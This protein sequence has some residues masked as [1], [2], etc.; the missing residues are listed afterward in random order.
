[1]AESPYMIK[2]RE[3]MLGLRSPDPKKE[4]KPIAKVSEKKKAQ[5][6]A[7]KAAGVK[8]SPRKP[9]P[10]GGKPRGRSEKMRGVVSALRPLYDAFMKDKEECEIKS[11]VCTGRAEYIHHVEGRG[12]KVIL[13]QSKWKACCGAC[14]GYVEVKDAEAKEKGHK[15][16]RLAKS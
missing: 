6:E 11:P 13:D 14:N 1:M 16:S 2:R 15:K 7:D 8:S 4:P 9:L 3:Q 10:K 5:Q 12:I